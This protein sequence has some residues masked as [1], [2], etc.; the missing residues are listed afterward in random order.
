MRELIEKVLEILKMKIS[1]NGN[2]IYVYVKF[3]KG[4]IYL[5]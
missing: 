3:I 1:E 2:V 4:T 5:F